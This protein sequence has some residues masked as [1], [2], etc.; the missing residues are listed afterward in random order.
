M[1]MIQHHQDKISEYFH[2]LLLELIYHINQK[3]V[4][5]IELKKNRD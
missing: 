3:F 5:D 1:H 4:Q 2:P